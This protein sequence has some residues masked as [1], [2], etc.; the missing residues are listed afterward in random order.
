MQVYVKEEYVVQEFIKRNWAK[1]LSTT[2][3]AGGIAYFA[4][5]PFLNGNLMEQEKPIVLEELAPSS[6]QPFTTKPL[7]I[8]L[9][10]DSF[11]NIG[12]FDIN[13][14][15]EVE[16]PSDA[17]R[18]I[19]G[20]K[21]YFKN[22]CFLS[23]QAILRGEHASERSSNLT[24]LFEKMGMKFST[25]VENQDANNN[26][27]VW[28]FYNPDKCFIPS[29]IIT[30]ITPLTR[31]IIEDV[32]II[33]ELSETVELGSLAFPPNQYV[34][35]E[36]M[37]KQIAEMV[38]DNS[39]STFSLHLIME[40]GTGPV[41]NASVAAAAEY[42]RKMAERRVEAIKEYFSEKY[43]S[44]MEYRVDYVTGNERKLIIKGDEKKS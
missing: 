32:A 25:T 21:D 41:K 40:V 5:L 7:T 37:K 35:S 22:D 17:V 15:E 19:V 16:V 11:A 33:N 43:S 14:G 20:L 29:E 38:G 26:V 6:I 2:G 18:H 44:E 28:I 31:D 3:A 23:S 42:N 9:Q 12:V 4:C 24:K 1:M 39:L 13:F 27:T 30:G 36:E 10:G 34:I 8:A